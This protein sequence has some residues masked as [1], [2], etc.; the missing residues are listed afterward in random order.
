MDTITVAML[1]KVHACEDQV[2]LFE[3]TF[4]KSARVTLTNCRKAAA[5]GLDLDW[6]SGQMLSFPARE[7]YREA[8]AF[9][10]AAYREAWTTPRATHIEAEATAWEA[11]LEARATGFYHAVLA[12]AKGGVA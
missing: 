11:F 4:G 12:K 7:A 1:R 9:A 5:A 6:A 2:E 3:R 8:T 10:W